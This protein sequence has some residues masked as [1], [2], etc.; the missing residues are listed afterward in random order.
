MST[1]RSRLTVGEIARYRAEG[2]VQPISVIESDVAAGLR[3]A[4]AEHIAGLVPTERYELTDNVKVGRIEKPDGSASYEY[5]D[6]EQAEP[7]TLPFLFNIWRLDV[8]F[9]AV[10][11]DRRIATMARQLLG[12]DDVLLMEDNVVAKVPGAGVVPWHQDLSYWPVDQPSVVTLWIA[13]DNIEPRNGA[14]TVV[15]GSHRTVEHLP[16]QFRDAATF[17]SEHRPG[18][19][20]LS[21]DPVADGRPVVIYQLRPGEAGFH[22]PLLWHG[23]TPNGSAEVRNAYVLRYVASGTP[24][25][26]SSRVPY[27]DIGCAVGDPITGH[28]LPRV[29]TDNE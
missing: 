27:D 22:H 11:F 1:V 2:F 29:P 9:R 19:P 3:H 7:H 6:E 25:L 12:C 8:R 23:S 16:V 4:A 18:V 15:P 5:L 20:T 14:M 10:A 26:G 28:H 24:W 13:L 17:M 21:Q